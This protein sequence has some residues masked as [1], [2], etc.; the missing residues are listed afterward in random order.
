MPK[1]LV[2][3]RVEE[4]SLV[5][6]PANRRKFLLT[7]QEDVMNE[8]ELLELMKAAADDESV[9]EDWLSK[10]GLSEKAAGAVRGATR[11][12]SAFKDEP[13]MQKLMQLLAA[14]GGFGKPMGD[15]EDKADKADKAEKTQKSEDALPEKVQKRLDD[16]Q[17][18]LDA[19]KEKVAKAEATTKA[20]ETYSRIP[21][22]PEE[23]AVL[24]VKADKA[25]EDISKPLNVLLA[26]INTA[27]AG[28]YKQIGSD[29]P[30][31]SAG[32]SD[33][34][35]EVDKLADALVAKDAN[36]MTHQQAVA[37]V[38]E[39]HPELY[40]RYLNSK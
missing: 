8:K 16:M 26:A 6:K 28:L 13:G 27:M 7:K 12:L 36:G 5:G 29:A 37:K 9:L 31:V 3:L 33:V 15:E 25:G 10:A 24:L 40:T 21:G 4:V 11:L 2:D 23:L 32:A 30:A 20:R 35:A 1:Q 38:L 39:Q 34:V 19:A 17:K 18:E 22:N 14:M